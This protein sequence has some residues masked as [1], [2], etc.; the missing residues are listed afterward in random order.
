MSISPGTPPPPKKKNCL[1]VRLLSFSSG[2]IWEDQIGVLTSRAPRGRLLPS[3]SVARCNSAGGACR[4]P[5]R[6]QYD[7]RPDRLRVVR[8]HDATAVAQS[9]GS[10]RQQ[11]RRD[12]RPAPFILDR[13]RPVTTPQ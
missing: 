6:D 2:P 7:P 13:R 1:L 3:R 5:L 9:A 11:K 8:R 10:L 4:G 12:Q